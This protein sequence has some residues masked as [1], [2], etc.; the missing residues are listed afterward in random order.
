MDRI[1]I[2][3]ERAVLEI[4]SQPTQMNIQTHRPSFHVRNVKPVMRVSRKMPSFKV[5]WMEVRASQSGI[6]PAIRHTKE[7]AT[8]AQQMVMEGIA[9]VAQEGD[10]MTRID[11][12][13]TI[14]RIIRQRYLSKLP[15]LNIKTVPDPP[16]KIEW[17]EGHM[18]IEWEDYTLELDWDTQPSPVIQ[19]EPHVVEIRLRNHP[20]IKIWVERD[21]STGELRSVVEG[22]ETENP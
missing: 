9:R 10:K 1:R 7:T 18:K 6:S 13:Q 11:L 3:S 22:S 20:S 17:E 19:V 8:K 12:N 16:A 14:P 2:R 4:T 21:Q 15:E 5:N